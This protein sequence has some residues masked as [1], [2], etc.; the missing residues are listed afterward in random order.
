MRLH[1]IERRSVLFA[2]PQVL[3]SFDIVASSKTRGHWSS[4]VEGG[5][6]ATE[7][8]TIRLCTLGTLTATIN[9]GFIVIWIIVSQNNWVIY[10]GSKIRVCSTT[11]SNKRAH[12]G[13]CLNCRLGLIH[14]DQWRGPSR[15]KR[16]SQS[17]CLYCSCRRPLS[18]NPALG[19]RYPG[20]SQLL[21]SCSRRR[22]C[23]YHCRRRRRQSLLK[24]SNSQ[25]WLLQPRS[26]FQN[27]PWTRALSL[28]ISWAAAAADNCVIP[29][30]PP[31]SLL[32]WFLSWTPE[33]LGYDFSWAVVR[34]LGREAVGT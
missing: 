1:V 19:A 4:G 7:K 28:P 17:L 3:S 31:L 30:T 27:V 20:Y 16:P 12:L 32:L 26:R 15:P 21:G 24:I 34:F 23:H 9:V 8:S 10:T 14:Y 33:D 22:Y 29:S 18:E 6:W 5:L 25:S 13:S 11:D 2:K